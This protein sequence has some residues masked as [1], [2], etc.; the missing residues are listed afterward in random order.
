MLYQLSYQITAVAAQRRL[1]DP[2][3]AVNIGKVLKPPRFRIKPCA[4]GSRRHENR[5]LGT[6][7]AARYP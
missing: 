7:F 4:A 6:G 2:A 5:G 1:P 3:A